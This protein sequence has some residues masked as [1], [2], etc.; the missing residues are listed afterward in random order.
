MP[1]LLINPI[2]A[3][4]AFRVTTTESWGTILAGAG[5]GSDVN[6]DV[7]PGFRVV[8]SAVLNQ[9]TT[10]V[11]AIMLF[12]P[13][14]LGIP[15]NAIISSTTP[16]T[17]QIFTGVPADTPGN[18]NT[19]I[20][21][22]SPASNITLVNADYSQVGTTAYSNLLPMLSLTT[23]GYST[24]TFNAT[25]IAAMQALVGTSN[26]LKLSILT[27]NDRTATQPSWSAASAI[28][29]ADMKYSNATNPPILTIPYTVTGG[30]TP[31]LLTLGVG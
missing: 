24:W 6:N 13:F 2:L 17:L 20:S 15:S 16:P 23:D 21:T 4:R 30:F 8:T 12:D 29:N 26:L 27:E 9:F 25:G 5:T 28:I 19:V 11:R 1:Q 18:T 7:T 22:S 31:Q 3:G 10:N 14:T